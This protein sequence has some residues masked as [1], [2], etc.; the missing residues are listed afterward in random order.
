M[1]EA[2]F[3]DSAGTKNA[4]SNSDNIIFTI[5]DTKSYVHVIILSAKAVKTS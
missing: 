2:F 3:S 5:K 4:D 1:D